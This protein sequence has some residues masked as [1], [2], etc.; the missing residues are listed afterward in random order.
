MA[1]HAPMPPEMMANREDS[2]VDILKRT[3]ERRSKLA[4]M[5]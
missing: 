3:N 2:A 5:Q 4:N 1:D